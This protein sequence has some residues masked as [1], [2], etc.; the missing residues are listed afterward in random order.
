MSQPITLTPEQHEFR[1]VVRQFCEDKI[2]PNAA[3]LDHRGEF[4]WENFEA[5]KSME[6]TSLSYP[7]EY[8]GAG[9]SLVDQA[10]VA[11]EL[12]RV[13]VS[14][15]LSF[16]ISKLGMLPVINFGSH[17]LKSKYIPRICSGESQCSYGLSEPDAGSDVASMTTKA[18]R[19]GNDWIITGTKCWITNAGISDLYTVFARTS[20]DRHKGITAFLVPCNTP[21]FEVPY[22]WWTFNMPSDHG[23]VE[24]RDVRIPADAVLG[25]VDRGLEVAQ[26]FLHENRIR[27]AASSLGAAQYCSD[28]AVDYAKT[29]VTFG[30]PLAVNQAVQWPLVELQTEAQMV[31][32]LVRYAATELDR[33]H[34]MEVSD[35]VSMA[36]YRANRLVCEAADRA[37]QIHGGI[38]YSRHEPF[39]HIY[40]HHRRYRITEGAEEIQMRRVAQR[41]FKF[42]RT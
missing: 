37:M 9:A 1:R 19:D 26:T 41:M 12:S 25:E 2:A 40:R 4:S 6:L 34:H 29:R 7:E 18:V 24:L 17:E 35:K 11:E 31:R 42:G 38:G 22:Y 36:N 32:L 14:T 39:E 16:L 21:G 27:Q 3:E 20:D 30:K 33:N 13:C 5:L 15:S 28:R 8:G 23:E 10:I